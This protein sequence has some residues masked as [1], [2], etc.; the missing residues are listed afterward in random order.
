MAYDSKKAIEVIESCKDSL[1]ELYQETISRIRNPP[2][3][4]KIEAAKIAVDL[5]KIFITISLA[6]FAVI[7]LFARY[8]ISEGLMLSSGTLIL[9]FVSAALVFLVIGFGLTAISTVYKSLQGGAEREP[10]SIGPI[11]CWLNA[12][13]WTGLA[14]ILSFLIAVFIGSGSKSYDPDMLMLT[15]ETGNSVDSEIV[16]F[17]PPLLISGGTSHINIYSEDGASFGWQIP[18]QESGES[19]ETPLWTLSVSPSE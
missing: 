6:A 12:Q 14:S 15:L 3:A 11:R 13:A 10:W 8:Y 4:D 19:E 16:A 1:G 2:E 18:H 17:Y 9:L 5:S 7:G